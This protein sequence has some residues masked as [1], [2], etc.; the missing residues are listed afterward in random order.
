MT[1]LLRLQ[2]GRG[3]RFLAGGLAD[4]IEGDL[5]KVAF[6]GFSAHPDNLPAGSR[7]ARKKKFKMTHYL[8]PG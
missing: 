4:H 5:G 2:I 1:G 8:A 6:F 7:A 3:G